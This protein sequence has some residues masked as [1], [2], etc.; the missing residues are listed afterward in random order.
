VWSCLAKAGTSAGAK[1]RMW[2][3]WR[4]TEG[5]V[6]LSQSITDITLTE[7]PQRVSWVLPKYTNTTYTVNR[8]NLMLGS[9]TIN[10][11]V[12]YTD[13]K[14]EEGN[15]ATTWIPHTTDAEYEKYSINNTV[16][17]ISGY[18]HNGTQIGTFSWSSDT[19]RYNMSAVF[20]GTDSCIQ[21]PFNDICTNGDIFTMNIWWK[22]TE[23]GSKSYETL[24]G[25]PSG[26]EMDTRAGSATTLSL[27]MASIRGGNVRGFNMNEWYMITLVNDGTNELYYVNGV[28]VKTIE[29][30]NMPSGN[31]YIGAWQTESK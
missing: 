27:Y 25:G 11:E 14:I 28:L 24:I 3:H 29:K 10:N 12:Y 17:D 15:V 20:N 2:C 31:Y 30:K 8:I 5:G 16:H 4:S 19:P 6:N 26:F 13:V 21:F 23:L 18:G 22:K 7:T 9:A 1:L